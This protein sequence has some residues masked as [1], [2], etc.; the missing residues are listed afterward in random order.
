M[1]NKHLKFPFQYNDGSLS[2]VGCYNG[3]LCLADDDLMNYLN[4][5]YFWILFIIDFIELP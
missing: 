4:N 1:Y 3:M 2:I 5:F